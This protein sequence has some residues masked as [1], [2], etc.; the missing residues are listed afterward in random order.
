MKGSIRIKLFLSLVTLVM[1]ATA[2]AIPLIGSVKHTH[3][4]AFSPF[5]PTPTYEPAQ[6]TVQE[7]ILYAT[8]PFGSYHLNIYTLNPPPAGITPIVLYFYGCCNPDTNRDNALRLGKT[9]ADPHEYLF[10]ALLNNGY[11]VATLDYPS[12][13]PV[14]NSND[15]E[16]G[17][18]AVRFLRANAA[19]YN[20]DSTRIIAWG[21]SGGGNPVELM[22]TADQSAG[23]DIGQN[24]NY[25]S[26]VE[27]VVDWYGDVTNLSYITSDDAPFL[28]QQGAKD[29]SFLKTDSKNLYN[30]LIAANVYAQLQYVANAGHKFAP[31][32]IGSTTNPTY[33]GIAQSAVSFLNAKVRDNSNPLPQ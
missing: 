5:N 11:R 9:P 4:A 18:A 2:S 1:M 29:S 15:V 30:A 20:I 17:K 33:E 19:T 6:W 25:S 21:S 13:Y 3:A 12:E 7:G 23:F 27:A 28:I 31:S 10:R 16:A 26:R 22:G 14:V 24:L 32:P 8:L